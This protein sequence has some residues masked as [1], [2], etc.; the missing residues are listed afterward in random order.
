LYVLFH[1][2]SEKEHTKEKSVLLQSSVPMAPAWDY[3]MVQNQCYKPTGLMQATDFFFCR[4][5]FALQGEK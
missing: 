3:N 4:S 2:A 5:F 1:P